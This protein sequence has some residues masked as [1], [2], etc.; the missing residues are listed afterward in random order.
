MK[1]R[2]IKVAAVQITTL[3]VLDVVAFFAYA[4]IASNRAKSKAE[5]VC[6]SVAIGADIVVA[7][8]AIEGAETEA[9]F[10]SVSPNFLSVGFHGA[11]VERWS[12]SFKISDGKVSTNEVRL[13]D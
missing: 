10:R 2:L 9:R 11:F 1:L 3:F 4:G 5:A 6:N 12:C 7:A 13:I 8:K